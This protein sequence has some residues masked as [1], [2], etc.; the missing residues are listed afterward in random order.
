M[1]RVGMQDRITSPLGAPALMHAVG[2]GALAV[3]IRTGDAKARA[4]LAPL[5]HWPSEWRVGAER[6]LLRVL[7]G[8]CSVPVGVET[9]LTEVDAATAPHYPAGTFA[10]L[11]TSSAT[12]HFSGVTSEPIPASG[13]PALR[14][15]RAALD[16]KACVTS[17]DGSRHVLYEPGPVVLSSYQEAERWGEDVARQLRTLGAGEIL[18]EIEVQRKQREK[19]LQA[20][21][22]AAR[23][24]AL[25]L[26]A[27][28]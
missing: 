25:A 20:E 8:G 22:E 16:L 26:Q 14:A 15:R 10:P 7:E 5:G 21:G 28:A 18:E 4:A 12:L 11:T 1:T 24:A 13:M 3:E 9:E 6:G 17:P 27:Q 23:A 2:Q 19:E